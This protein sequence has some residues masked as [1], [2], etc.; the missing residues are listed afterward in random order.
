MGKK[1]RRSTKSKVD[2]EKAS[3]ENDL[4]EEVDEGNDVMEDEIDEGMDED[5]GNDEELDIEE[6]ELET[7]K[8]TGEFLE[9]RTEISRQ[10]EEEREEEEEITEERTY[11]V[12]LKRA[13]NKPPKKRAKK[14]INILREFFTRHMKPTELI[15]LPE[16]NEY[17]WSRGIEKPPR[18]IKIR[19]TKNLDG[20]VTLYLAI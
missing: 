12:P 2:E 3:V 10:F 9:E 16:V 17:V 19:A 11:I 1:R 15:I 13:Y 14:A 6:E 7:G 8:E 20:I 18:K 5:E 4:D